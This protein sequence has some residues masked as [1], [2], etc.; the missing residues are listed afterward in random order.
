MA[1][2][3]IVLAADVT[4]LEELRGLVALAASHEQVVGVKVGATLALRHGLPAVI[5][6]I[7]GAGSL[8][9]IYDHQK[10]GSDIPDL[11]MPF[12]RACAEAGADAVIIFPHA[13]PRTLKAFVSAAQALQLRP[14]VG[15]AMTHPAYFVSEGGYMADESA[16]E[17]CSLAVEMGVREFVVPGTKPA[18]LEALI[19]GPLALVDRPSL[20]MPGFG[21]QGGTIRAIGAMTRR[22]NF[23]PIVGSAVYAAS[24]PGNAL[25]ALIRELET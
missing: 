15:L 21:R 19:A 22:M 4:S 20:F 25:A 13:G 5:A 7:R 24:D 17:A 11:G 23:F 12:C 16:K 2:R 10:A 18:L 8:W 1:D 6:E 3:G 14:I 9:A